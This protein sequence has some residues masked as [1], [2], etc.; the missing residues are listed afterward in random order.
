M[1]PDSGWP[2]GAITRLPATSMA[3]VRPSGVSATL[4]TRL[5][6]ARV[7]SKAPVVE[8]PPAEG[9]ALRPGG[10]GK[11]GEQRRGKA[12]Q[13][14]SAGRGHAVNTS[15]AL[16]R[17]PV[18]RIAS[19]VTVCMRTQ[20][21][22]DLLPWFQR[23]STKADREF[24]GIAETWHIVPALY[25]YAGLTSGLRLATLKRFC[26]ALHCSP[27]AGLRGRERAGLS[28]APETKL[29][30]IRADGWLQSCKRPKQW[31]AEQPSHVLATPVT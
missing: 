20:T 7:R 22:K 1:C 15:S 16:C 24:P 30:S 6:P 29:N 28:E 14:G 13:Q 17:K 18:R 23:R 4:P 3:S 10:S 27:L 26:P 8:L 31:A 19:C 5:L 12:Q 21:D 9:V 2:T 11:D 25:A